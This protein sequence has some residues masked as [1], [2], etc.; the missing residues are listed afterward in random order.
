[1][2]RLFSSFCATIK[3]FTYIFEYSNI[4]LT[5]YA[6]G[7]TERKIERT[8]AGE[9][10]IGATPRGVCCEFI[11]TDEPET[12]LPA[13]NVRNEYIKHSIEKSF[14]AQLE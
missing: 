6:E 4:L 2:S 10:R 8:K 11:C 7:I 3:Q 5:N 13:G 9:E 1:M 12:V 14:G